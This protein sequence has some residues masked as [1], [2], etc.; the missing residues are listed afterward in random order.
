MDLNNNRIFVILMC[1]ICGFNFSEKNLITKMISTLN[2][3]G[4]DDSGYFVDDHISLGHTRLAIIDLTE[5]GRQPIHNESESIWIVFNGEIYNYKEMKNRLEMRGHDF[6][7]ETDTEVIIHAYEEYGIECLNKFNGQFSFCIYD[8]NKKLLFLARDRFGIKPLYYF[9]KE[10]LFI[11]ASEIKSILKH[12]FQ[13]IINRLA[14]RE[15][16]TF[17]YTLAPN[18]ILNDIY[19]LEPSH[20]ILF[21]IKTN[22]FD[23]QKYYSLEVIKNKSYSPKQVG[24]ELFK[25]IN[26]S[27]KLRMIADVPVCSFLSGGIDSSII[28]GLASKYNDNIH[29]FSVG[30]ETSNEFK[31]AKIVSEFYNTNHHELLITN[32]D[33]LN[34]I[35]KM[36]YHM[37]EPIG[38]A[39]FFPTLLL[40]KLISRQF[41]VVLAGEGADEL[42]GGYDRYKMFLYGK[43]ISYFLPKINYNQTILRR[44]SILSNKKE[45]NGYIETIRAFNQDEMNQMNIDPIQIDKLWLLYGDTFQKMQFFDLKSVLPE[46]FFMKADKMSSAYGLEER[47]PYMDHNLVKFALNLPPKLKLHFWNEKYLLKKTF[48]T[49]LPKII[50]KRR[51]RG[52]NAPMDYWLKT[53]LH[54]RF[55]NLLK[56]N[57][58]NLYN[59]NVI[60]NLF[61]KLNNRGDNYKKNFFLAQKCWTAYVFEEWLGSLSNY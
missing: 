29:T 37:D 42:F 31:Y 56:E 61:N 15:Y 10:N 36:I 45:K 39:A 32:D 53:V 14:L 6:Y 22:Q 5:K 11:F 27:V 55:L 8:K 3:R 20:Y 18:T 59:K 38:D 58:H 41:K 33:L 25:L 21:N 57:S 50:I 52:Y 49:F 2:H 43:K 44:L 12:E 51:K 60:I 23:I 7:T 17:R 9:L 1:G 30:F 24:V 54:D 19:K 35:D 13:R 26:N 46:D 4:P 16:F 40:S 47:V 34:N 28:T 48:S